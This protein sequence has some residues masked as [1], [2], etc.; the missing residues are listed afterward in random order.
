MPKRVFFNFLNLFAICFWN[1]LARVEYEWNSGLKFF[2]LFLSLSYPVLAKNNAGKGF[3]NFLFCLYFFR[4][5]LSRVDYERSSGLKFCSLFLHLF[6]PILAKNNA[7]KS[8]FNFLNFLDIFFRVSF[9]GSC[10]N[11]IQV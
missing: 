9:H 3:F 10:M 8:F 7:R 5:F 6:H 4:N 2:S 11:R 1:F